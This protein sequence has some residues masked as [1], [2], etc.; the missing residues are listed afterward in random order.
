MT[1][2][3]LPRPHATLK[4][5]RRGFIR[6]CVAGLTIAQIPLLRSVAFAADT[7]TFD[8]AK[9]EGATTIV[10]TSITLPTNLLE[11]GKSTIIWADTLILSGTY[12]TKG[13]S[14][15]V[16][17]RKITAASGTILK[18]K[19]ADGMSY[20][21]QGRS[22]DGQSPGASGTPGSAGADGKPGGDIILIADELQGSI[23]LDTRGGN[24]GNG[25]SGGNGA[26]GRTGSV[27]PS[28]TNGGLGGMGGGAGAG[29]KGGDA[30]D[31]GNVSA[32]I[33]P[34]VNVANISVSSNAGVPGLGGANGK[35]GTGGPGGGGGGA[36]APPPTRP[37]CFHGGC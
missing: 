18:S 27:G 24:G 4:N 2:L 5:S 15:L 32:Q 9:F 22:D 34:D 1:T 35:A 8:Q 6:G 30:G 29:G 28:C 20:L 26:I 16:V 3:A 33:G 7:P 14:L 12:E 36:L 31:G 11:T 25:Q 37:V 23:V 17:A 10:G 13:G 21:P 19:G